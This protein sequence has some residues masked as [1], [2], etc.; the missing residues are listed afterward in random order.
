MLL[1]KFLPPEAA[2]DDLENNH[3]KV[4]IIPE[5]NDPFELTTQDINY[6]D[7][8]LLKECA[9]KS[10]ETLAL[11]KIFLEEYLKR[12]LTLDEVSEFVQGTSF[13]KQ[14]SFQRNL[15]INSN[16]QKQLSKGIGL[17]SFSKINSNQ[18]QSDLLLWS[19]YANS[20]KGIVLNFDLYFIDNNENLRQVN[21]TDSRIRIPSLKILDESENIQKELFFQVATCKSP[22][23]SYENEYRWLVK[24]KNC[25]F[26][27]IQTG[28]TKPFLNFPTEALKQV[29]F[30]CNCSE[31]H[32][33]KIKEIL[34][35]ERYNHVELYKAKPHPTDFKLEYK[36]VSF[37]KEPL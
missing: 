6:L 9:K 3:L 4:S 21:Y 18:S 36:K 5:L 22:V 26:K 34:Q 11:A 25:E 35:E 29:I 33:E 24:F 16:S 23:W 30:G 7:E 37:S 15:N 10:P 17:I 27:K 13:L 31:E 14:F 1:T 2:I 20:H 12:S 28:E 32:K 8:E 19:H